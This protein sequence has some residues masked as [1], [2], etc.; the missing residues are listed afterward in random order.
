[1]TG[2][3]RREGAVGNKATPGSADD[4]LRS[5]HRP[6]R[7]PTVLQIEAVECGAAALGMVLAYYGRWASLTELR[8]ACGV[9]RDGAKAI[10]IASAARS[11]GLEVKAMRLESADLAD[12][13]GPAILWWNFNHF[14]VFEG[15][16]RGAAQINDPSGGRRLVAAHEFDVSFTGVVLLFEPGDG[17]ERGGQSVGTFESIRGR[18]Q[19]A[20]AGLVLAIAAGILATV[21][22]VVA[23]AL[24]GIFIDDVLATGDRSLLW[25]LVTGIAFCALFQVAATIL[26]QWQLLRVQNSL[27]A[28]TAA[29]FLW[30]VLRLPLQF[31]GVRGVAD[32]SRR[33]DANTTV[34]Q[35]IGVQL[36]TIGL[37]ALTA[38]I[39][40]G[41]MLL[42]SWP[43]ALVVFGLN[44]LN[45]VALRSV[46]VHR[47]TA[48]RQLYHLR[49]SLAAT[50]YGG[51]RSIETL[52]AT[53]SE[54]DYFSRWAGEQ[55]RVVNV[56]NELAPPTVILGAVPSAISALSIAAIVIVG[57]LQVIDDAMTL[58]DLVAFQA[59]TLGFTA[60][61]HRVV[62][63]S[64]A[65]QDISSQLRRLDDVLDEPVDTAFMQP[66]NEQAETEIVKLSGL[67]EVTDATF[68]YSSL[69]P[70][71]IEHFS[72]R[73]EPGQRVAL[74]GA[75]GAGKSTI[76]KL[77][78]GL[79]DPWSGSVTF[80]GCNVKSLRRELIANS[81]S[82]VEQ[83]GTLF[84]GTVAQ[85]L[86]M[87]DDTIEP[88]DLVAS[89][90]AAQIH[91]EIVS[92]PSAYNA[93]IDEGGRN[94]SGGERQRLQLA[95]ALAHRPTMLVL[96]EATSALDPITE[97]SVNDAIRDLGVSSLVVAH[98]L[99]TIREADEIIVLDRGSI[100]ERGTH[101]ELMAR[102]GTYRR[103]VGA[104]G[105]V[106]E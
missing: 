67:I 11:Y 101:D 7:T 103:L 23:P 105:D 60:P 86:S 72:M 40:G 52:K 45:A 81:F 91:D 5:H 28:V 10:H 32:V 27:A 82:I 49:A 33:M 71:L 30:R 51:L 66:D 85:N 93:I 19:H 22:G 36:S 34:A 59:L 48:N 87:W 89:A 8:Q 47:Q 75:S 9:S 14:V 61:I 68:G 53:S 12:L 3:D 39:Y 73:I 17:F 26:Q 25:L 55:A 29:Q 70:P 18:T 1:M 20:R 96:D 76:V 77:V 92:R 15:F 99:S 97:A 62:N 50:T 4:R 38:V 98:R 46:L 35:L 69:E 78:A 106:G 6:H 16:R 2:T 24:T 56:E 102:D 95:R 94:W 64:G 104:G 83:S 84:A 21:P 88:R 42:Y 65:L 100:V 31:F 54:A 79:L 90:S 43:L 58:G 37:G 44:M 74:V 57:G 80:D 63:A 13:D 41:V